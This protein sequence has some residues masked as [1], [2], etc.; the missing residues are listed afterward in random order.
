MAADSF[1]AESITNNQN[2]SCW[3]GGE[4]AIGTWGGCGV[5]GGKRAPEGAS[6]NNRRSGGGKYCRALGGV[7]TLPPGVTRVI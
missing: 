6:A 3:F 7:R 5:C 2:V 4:N 1:S